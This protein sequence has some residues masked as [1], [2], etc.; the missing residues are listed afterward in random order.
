LHDQEYGSPDNSSRPG[1]IQETAAF[2]S[3]N[4]NSIFRVVSDN[5][6]VTALIDSINANC[7]LNLASSSSTSPFPYNASAL[8]A[9]KPEQAVEYYRAS[10]VVLTLDGYNNTDALTGEA[11]V[12]S[13]PLPAGIDTTLLDCLNQT[14]G[15][16]VPLIDSAS[17]RWSTSGVG[18]VWM[19]SVFWFFNLF[20]TF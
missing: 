16:S 18:L 19:V 3:N 11:N 9:P 1:G 14:I 10:S 15:L 5:T 2:Q 13:T 12:T 17:G 20:I 4:T 7:S 6:T 8:D